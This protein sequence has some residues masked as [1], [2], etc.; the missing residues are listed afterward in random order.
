M[1][2]FEL[3]EGPSNKFWEVDASG[4]ELTVRFGRTTFGQLFADY[5]ILQPFK[6]LGRETFSLTE[7]EAA[8]QS[9][10]RFN[11]KRVTPGGLMGLN[12]RGWQ[13]GEAL[14]GGGYYEFNKPLPGG[15][16]AHLAFS[17][18]L[19]VG[20]L[21][22]GGTQTLDGLWLRRPP[23]DAN[24]GKPEFLK[25]ETLDPVQASELLRDIDLIAPWKAPE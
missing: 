8:S 3:A 23:P 15:L 14:D 7:A 20:L 16:W 12:G 24:K 10:N 19:T 2:R 4:T 1:Q 9:L 5:E 11:A 18:G 25:F 6:Q 13:R 17:P 22:D 21:D